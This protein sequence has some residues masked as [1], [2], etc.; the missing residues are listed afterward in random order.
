MSVFVN[1]HSKVIFRGITGEHATF[2]AQDA[3][4]MG[5]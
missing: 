3:I 1:K 2:H 5:T 4:S